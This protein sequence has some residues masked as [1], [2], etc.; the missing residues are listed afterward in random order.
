[1]FKSKT[2]DG[3]CNICGPIVKIKRKEKGIS[4]RE[5]AEQLQLIGLDIDKNQVQRIECGKR[6][7]NDIEIGYIARALGCDIIDLFE[8]SNTG[9]RFVGK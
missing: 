8:K 6:Y 9:K 2:A 3:K 7:V 4:Q 5:F 1:M